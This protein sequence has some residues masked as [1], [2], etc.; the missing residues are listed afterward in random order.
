VRRT[1]AGGDRIPRV[2]PPEPIDPA[3]SDEPLAALLALPPPVPA[4]DAGDAGALVLLGLVRQWAS[5][6][7]ALRAALRRRAA[8]GTALLAALESGS[9][10]TRAELR[11]WVVG[12]DAVQLE[13]AGLSTEMRGDEP[14]RAAVETHL[15]GIRAALRALRD[16]GGTDARR[17]AALVALRERHAGERIVAFSQFADTV[18]SLFLELRGE[19]RIAALSAAGALVAGGRIAR[20]EAVARFAPR[21]HGRAEPRAAERIDL[22]LTTDLLSEGVNLQDASVIV[23][24]DL[25]W[26]PARLEQRIGRLARLGAMHERVAVYLMRPPAAA[27]SLLAMEHRLGAKI[28]AA[29]RV[30]GIPPAGVPGVLDPV[31]TMRASAPSSV[32]A[33]VEEIRALLARWRAATI[34]PAAEEGPLVAACGAP[35][36]VWIALLG[37]DESPR[38]FVSLDR[39]EPTED[40]EVVL[41]ALALAD[42]ASTIDVAT[43]AAARAVGDA[44]RALDR[45]RARRDTA[46]AVDLPRVAASRVRRALIRRLASIPARAPLHRRAALAPLV[47]RARL[48]ALAPGGIGAERMLGELAGAPLPDEAWLEALLGFG[49]AQRRR[50]EPDGDD[51]TA[52][53]ALLVSCAE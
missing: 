23:H 19:P 39:G 25:P 29:A 48:V 37:G 13:L 26:T 47:A 33:A 49:D 53:R 34:A 38:L 5:S 21:A 44:V 12:D 35:G 6:E 28:D 15:A 10:L 22:L 18:R 41:R 51:P 16:H 32:P 8:A 50:T 30:A 3:G 46:D 9:H 31:E 2:L 14:M 36:R 17:A 20:A 24:L 27:G 4:A 7:G 42:R 43:P 40:P 45:E 11:R 52:L 1:D